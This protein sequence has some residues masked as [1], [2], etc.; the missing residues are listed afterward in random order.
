MPCPCRE[1]LRLLGLIVAFYYFHSERVKQVALLSDSLVLKK[2]AVASIHF[3]R[4]KRQVVVLRCIVHESRQ[5]IVNA[6]DQSR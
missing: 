5:F 4:H 2:R 6:G 1:I 3:Q